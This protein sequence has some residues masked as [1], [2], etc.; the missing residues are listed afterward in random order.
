M[1]T[2]D[3][4]IVIEVSTVCNLCCPFCAHDSRLK[5]KRHTIEHEQLEA[6]TSVIG[7]FSI[8]KKESVLISWLGGEPFLN[9]SVLPLTEELIINFPLFF[10]AT[11][12]GTK[13]SNPIIR[14]HIKRCYSELTISIDG[15]A[16]F[17]D[18]MRGRVG[19]FEEVKN[20]IKLLIQEAPNL[21]IR[22]NTVL[23]R[24]NFDLFPDLC[25][26][27][28]DWGI[29]EITFNQLG[30]RDRPEFYPE[31]RLSVEQ[32]TRLPEFASHIQEAISNTQA[33]LIF[34]ENYFRRI[35]ATAKGE[36]LPIRDCKPGSYYMFVNAYG[37]ISPCSFTTDEYGV[38]MSS[39]QS[40]ADFEK[41][42]LVFHQ[43]KTNQQAYYCH[44][45]P[46]TN[47]HGKFS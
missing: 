10:S 11:T 44:D 8:A 41:L 7:K 4:V 45:C 24:E 42:P 5:V 6:F 22:I 23:M 13:L 19:L 36:K 40:L 14:G 37:R 38:D 21:K 12:N 30:G 47:V 20:S 39:I 34:S 9:K 35:L 33:K 28:A 27:F 29:K 1:D 18:K 46:C 31:N 17:H 26:E 25:I 15:F 2:Y 16:P 3:K 43:K 32:V